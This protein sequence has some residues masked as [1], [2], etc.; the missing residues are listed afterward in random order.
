MTVQIVK[1]TNKALRYSVHL[2]SGCRSSGL[3][4]L[5]QSKNG[6][7]SKKVAVVTGANK[8]IGLA[9]V[10]ELCKARFAGDVILTARNEKLG[11]E[12]VAMLKSEGFDV[13]YHHLDICDD[14]SAKKL[15]SFLQKTYG[16]LDVLVNNAGIAFKSSVWY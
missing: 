14:G 16:G 13:I 10:R 12:A 4:I 3:V 7:M 11:N 2:Q 15:S 9:I 6:R 5:L 8:G 1:V